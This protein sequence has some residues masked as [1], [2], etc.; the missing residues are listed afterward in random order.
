MRMTPKLKSNMAT[1]TNAM[2][3]DGEPA[4]T[5]GGAKELLELIENSMDDFPARLNRGMTRR[6][7][8]V[9]F[10]DCARNGKPEDILRGLI[11]KNI[12]AEFGEDIIAALAAA[13]RK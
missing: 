8:W 4:I 10:A 13:G 1:L 2:G 12:V 5:R 3:W 11:F 7:A 6:Q 9:I